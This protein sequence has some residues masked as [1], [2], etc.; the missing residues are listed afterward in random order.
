MLKSLDSAARETPFDIILDATKYSSQ[1]SVITVS[2]QVRGFVQR[3]ISKNG[4]EA[5]SEIPIGAVVVDPAKIKSK[6]G[7]MENLTLK[8]NSGNESNVPFNSAV[9]SSNLGGGV[10]AEF[11]LSADSSSIILDSDARAQW[12]PQES[13]T[14][15]ITLEELI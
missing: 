8:V 14:V 9:S 1:G 6:G 4:V 12:S 5:L 7:L 2:S 11:G 15:Y 13:T 3:E 10:G